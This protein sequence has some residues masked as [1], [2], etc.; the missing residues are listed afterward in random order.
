MEGGKK[1]TFMD[2]GHF[3]EYELNTDYQNINE[4]NDY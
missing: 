1:L 2:I 4:F 3:F